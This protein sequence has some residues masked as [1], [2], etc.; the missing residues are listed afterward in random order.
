[1]TICCG[2]NKYVPKVTVRHQETGQV[3]PNS[4]P[5]GQTFLST[6]NI[7]G[8]FFLLHILTVFIAYGQFKC[9]TLTNILTETRSVF[10]VAVV[11]CVLRLQLYIML[12]GR[13]SCHFV[14]NC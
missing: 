6:T 2:Y 4:D 7:H 8:R 9:E 10:A 1:M 14:N 12:C 3:M 5:E 11:H 13:R